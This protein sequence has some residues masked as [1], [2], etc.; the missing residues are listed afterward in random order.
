MNRQTSLPVSSRILKINMTNWKLYRW[1][2]HTRSEFYGK[3]KKKSLQSTNNRPFVGSSNY[4]AAA[5]ENKSDI[6]IKITNVEK[7][8]TQEIR[9]LIF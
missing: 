4:S 8:G 2:Y 7:S 6:S 9:Q 1:S 3:T 5:A